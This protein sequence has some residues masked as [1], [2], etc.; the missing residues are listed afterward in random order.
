MTQPP[1][2]IHDCVKEDDCIGLLNSLLSEFG[3]RPSKKFRGGLGTPFG[4]TRAMYKN[5]VCI[6]DGVE[7]DVALGGG[8]FPVCME[9]ISGR[10][11]AGT[12]V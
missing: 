8:E 5:V 7:T 12:G 10:E 9:E 1:S 2:R 11:L 3:H 4:V 6:F